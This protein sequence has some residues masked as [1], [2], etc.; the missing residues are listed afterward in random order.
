MT[1]VHPFSIAVVGAGL[2]GL[3][4]ARVLQLYGIAVTVFEREPTSSSRGQGGSLDMHPES[5]QYALETAQLTAQFR[6]VARPEGEEM[7]I[8]D[9]WTRMA[10][11]SSRISHHRHLKIPR[12][13]TDTAQDVGIAQK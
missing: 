8:L 12:R 10:R 9:N 6:K 1:S 5:G 7:K 11:S 2:G 3:V 4:L 13:R